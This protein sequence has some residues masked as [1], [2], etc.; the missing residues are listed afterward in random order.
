MAFGATR[1]IRAVV[2]EKKRSRSSVAF[3]F[4]PEKRSA[5]I[6][7]I[8]PKINLWLVLEL[9]PSKITF[10]DQSKIN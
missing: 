3:F 1:L 4:I 8:N 7:L 5:K 10:C 2:I 6:N 9:I